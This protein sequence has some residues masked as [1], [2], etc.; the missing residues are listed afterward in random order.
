MSRTLSLLSN[1]LRNLVKGCIFLAGLGV[2]V[3]IG[4]GLTIANYLSL[5]M[6]FADTGLDG[7]PLAENALLG[8]YLGGLFG[9]ADLASL[10]AAVMAV[11][12]YFCLVALF[13]SLLN[14]WQAWERRRAFVRDNNVE[15]IDEANGLLRAAFFFT[16]LF[17]VIA[18]P[19]VLWETQLFRFRFMEPNFPASSLAAMPGWPE[20]TALHSDKFIVQIMGLGA[21][22]YVALTGGSALL[23][24]WTAHQSAESFTLAMAYGAQMFEEVPPSDNRASDEQALQHFGYDAAG[25][26]IYDAATPIAYDP[27][28]Q[29]V[30]APSPVAAAPGASAEG[31]VLFDPIIANHPQAEPAT[32]A[33]AKGAGLPDLPPM[34]YLPAENSRQNP[35][36]ADILEVVGGAAGERVSLSEALADPNRYHVDLM[37]R[38]IWARGHWER[39]H[40]PA[41]A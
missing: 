29:P 16:L 26:P 7:T 13:H 12:E 14:I 5:S 15:G 24:E 27:Q 20:L 32:A 36:G 18:V 19:L 34:P 21:W 37:T 11:V 4:A 2:S 17:A 25:Q 9:A 3:A 8:R 23:L 6:T 28:G 30:G 38:R 10:F 31:P 33:A 22:A 41:A 40:G 1:S 39:L 35:A